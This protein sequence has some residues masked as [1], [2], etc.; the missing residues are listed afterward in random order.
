MKFTPL[1]LAGAHVISLAPKTDDRGHFV[2]TFCARAFAEAGLESRFVQT[3]RSF[4][5]RRG[6]LRGFHYQLPPSAEVKLV[7]CTRGAVHDVIVDL[8]PD[9]PSFLQS[10]AIE[11]S[12]SSAT[13]LYVPRGCAHGF[14]TLT[15]DVEIQYQVSAAHDPVAE[16]GLRHDDPALQV[17]WPHGVAS[18]SDKD[19]SWP[20][21]DPVYHGTE[22]LRGLLEAV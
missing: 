13:G 14:V 17:H 19:R 21:F 20:D 15:D 10:C 3:N 5:A 6:T 16:R 22:A 4:S 12:D 1:P 7:L 9:S 18:L 8:R 2:R 11:L